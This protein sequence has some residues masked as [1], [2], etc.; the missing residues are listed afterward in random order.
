[1]EKFSLPSLR[2]ISG[3]RPLEIFKKIGLKSLATD[4]YIEIEKA[5]GS[6]E[7]PYILIDSLKEKNM[8][9]VITDDGDIEKV[10]IHNT[11]CGIRPI[12]YF[13][14]I[15][16][17]PTNDGKYKLIGDYT[18]EVEYGYYPQF[19]VST[20]IIDKASISKKF[21]IGNL[22]FQLLTYLILVIIYLYIYLMVRIGFLL[23]IS[24]L[25]ILI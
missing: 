25:M 4:F 19:C 13:S 23:N 2:H 16:G 24:L 18:L 17:I 3:F 21:F 15:K 7:K 22:K 5:H 14:K 10:N 8:I 11:S 1:M 6:L 9:R 12:L 20:N